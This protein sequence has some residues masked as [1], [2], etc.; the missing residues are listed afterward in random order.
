MRHGKRLADAT[1]INCSAIINPN[2]GSTS[3]PQKIPPEPNIFKW[4]LF[5]DSKNS[6]ADFG[7]MIIGSSP[8][9]FIVVAF[10][11]TYGVDG[12]ERWSIRKHLPKP[13][14]SERFTSLNATVKPL[15]KGR[16]ATVSSPEEPRSFEIV[17]LNTGK[18]A[19]AVPGRPIATSVN[20]NRI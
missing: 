16:F 13:E 11:R 2:G 17:D 12:T 15:S 3:E 19:A 14:K 6:L 1:A 5:P 8:C 20:A 18:T 10:V 9:E 4:Q 7:P